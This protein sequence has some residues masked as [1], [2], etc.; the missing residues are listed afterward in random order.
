MAAKTEDNHEVIPLWIDGKPT[1]ASKSTR[2]PVFRY[3]AEKIVH[4]AESADVEAAERACSSAWRAFEAWKTESAVSRRR[5]LQRYAELLRQHEDELVAAQRIETSV[6]EMWAKKNVHL[7]ADLI[8]E[9]AACITRLAGEIPPTQ[10]PGSMALVFAVPV[11][12][13]LSIAP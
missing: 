7:A 10:T 11:G 1:A 13:V 3:E 5:L 8:E 12:P 4:W 9:T 2:F 6:S